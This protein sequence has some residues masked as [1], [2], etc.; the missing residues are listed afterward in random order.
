MFI[1]NC[2]LIMVASPPAAAV[3]KIQG[4]ENVRSMSCMFSCSAAFTPYT[5]RTSWNSLVWHQKILQLSS[6]FCKWLPSRRVNSPSLTAQ[7]SYWSWK[8]W[9]TVMEA[10][11]GWV[12]EGRV[13]RRYLLNTLNKSLLSKLKIL[14]NT[15]TLL[16]L[17][18]W[19]RSRGASSPSLPAQYCY[20]GWK[21]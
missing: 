18:K 14:E 10:R 6:K 21:Y 12:A 8:L 20:R 7:Y 4:G 19:L 9:N 11:N 5:I 3:E 17:I 13:Q 2:L 16:S 1:A 15:R